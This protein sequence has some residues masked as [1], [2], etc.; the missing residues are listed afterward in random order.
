MPTPNLR[1]KI[2]VVPRADADC[3]RQL[4]KLASKIELGGS[5]QTPNYWSTRPQGMFTKSIFI[6]SHTFDGF[7]YRLFPVTVKCK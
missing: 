4:K 2:Q 6:M 1:E 5:V 7:S 3:V